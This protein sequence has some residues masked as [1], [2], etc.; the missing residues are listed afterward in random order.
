MGAHRYDMSELDLILLGPPGAGKGTQSALLGEDFGLPH[1]S[2][3]DM[4]R[5]AREEQTELGLVAQGYMDRGELVPDD[6][7]TAMIAER[8]AED[9]AR[10]GFL[11]DGFP[12]TTLQADALADQLAELGRSLTAVLLIDA[13]D[14]VALKR[15]SGRRVSPATGR[16]YHVDFDPPRR[17]GRCDIDG[18]ELI[19]REDDRAETVR[20]R[21]EVYHAQTEPLIAYYEERGL[22]WRFD[23]TLPPDQVHAHIRA[24]LATAQREESL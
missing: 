13:P 17:E 12:R 19:Q 7:I 16:V 9:D 1:I 23:G 24:A 8:L 18:S 20:R 15:I 4:L 10:D 3:G 5:S 22:L 6:V 11:L 14:E 2:T 21:L